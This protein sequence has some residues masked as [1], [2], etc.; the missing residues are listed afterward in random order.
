MI[1]V[2]N[3]LAIV[4]GFIA[5]V[6]KQHRKTLSILGIAINAIELV[7]MLLAVMLGHR[8]PKA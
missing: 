1:V 8:L 4:M 3:A 5:A 2:I 6:R 7:L